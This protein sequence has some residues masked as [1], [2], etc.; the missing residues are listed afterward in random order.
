MRTRLE[1]LHLERAARTVRFEMPPPT[2]LYEKAC[3]KVGQPFTSREGDK[4]GGVI[5]AEVPVAALWKALNDENHHA[6]EDSQIPVKHSEVIGGTPRGEDRMVF[7]WASQ[8]GMG[9]WWVSRV[10]MNRELYEGS[11][12]LLWELL[13]DDKTSDVDPDDAPMNLISSDLSPVKK[14][15][16][17]WLLVPI[18]EACTLVEYF[19]WSDPGGVVGFAQ[20]LIFTKGMRKTM[21]GMVEFAGNYTTTGLPGPSF[22]LP[23]GTPL[24]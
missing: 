19:N 2:K 4:A 14:S 3:K 5:V 13:W 1:E 11:D 20:P 10:W 12:G 22:L 21:A 16:G 15:Q 18:A 17:A 8:M 9:R 6:D 7:Q 23:D 24:D